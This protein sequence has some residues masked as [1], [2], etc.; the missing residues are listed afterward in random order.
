MHP[1]QVRLQFSWLPHFSPALLISI[2]SSQSAHTWKPL[3][4]ASRSFSFCPAP[5]LPV[6]RPSPRYA[7]LMH[8]GALTRSQIQ[9]R[10]I[11]LAPTLGAVNL[12]LTGLAT[13]SSYNVSARNT[14]FFDDPRLR[15]P[16]LASVLKCAVLHAH[17]KGWSR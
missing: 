10:P 3:E 16:T 14:T 2:G 7:P 8:K 4:P 6:L 11:T 13:I 12:G 9:S 5:A 15:F 1:R 17:P